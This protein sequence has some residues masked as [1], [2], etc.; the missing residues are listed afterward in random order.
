MP[1]PE[2]GGQCFELPQRPGLAQYLCHGYTVQDFIN[3][4]DTDPGLV[5]GVYQR[6]FGDEVQG[7]ESLA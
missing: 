6:K 2:A 7:H 4:Y 1:R 5:R 3:P